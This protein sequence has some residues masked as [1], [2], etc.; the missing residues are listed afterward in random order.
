MGRPPRRRAA[1]AAADLDELRRRPVNRGGPPTDDDRLDAAAL[2]APLTGGHGERH[3]ALRVAGIGD[4]SMPGY[5][6]DRVVRIMSALRDRLT[7]E[8]DTWT[9]GR[10]SRV[11]VEQHWREALQRGDCARCTRLCHSCAVWADALGLERVDD[12]GRPVWHPR[13]TT[14]P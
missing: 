1:S 2:L 8:I 14:D 9:Y 11:G 4:H 3:E 5:D 12:D 6:P 10:I 13:P 7:Q